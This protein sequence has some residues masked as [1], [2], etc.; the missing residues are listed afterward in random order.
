[1]IIPALMIYYHSKAKN[2]YTIFHR[3]IMVGLLFSWF[4][5]ILLHFSNEHVEVYFNAE[6]YFLM[7]LSAFLL[8]QFFYA[9]AFSLRKGKNTIFNRRIYQLVLL[10]LYGA[11]MI[12][13]LYNKLITDA[14]NYRVPVIVYTLVILVMLGAALNRYGKVN[15]VSYMLVALGA[16]LF[17]LSDSMLAINRFYENF[18]FARIFIMGS[19]V[20]AQYFIAIGCLRRDFDLNTQSV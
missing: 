8:T 12:W 15:G 5:D 17:V 16:F 14:G 1:M 9:V 20:M 2:A 11:G 3:L 4:G 10:V 7:G 19:Y 6:N 13:F 18:D